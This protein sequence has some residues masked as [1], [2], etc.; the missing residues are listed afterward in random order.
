MSLC[1]SVSSLSRQCS[2]LI[3][4]S[5]NVQAGK[6]GTLTS[7]GKGSKSSSHSVINV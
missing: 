5:R 2:G 1:K 3:S 4:R 7:V 6:E